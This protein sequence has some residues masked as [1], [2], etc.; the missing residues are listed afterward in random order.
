[1]FRNILTVARKNILRTTTDTTSVRIE[2]KWFDVNDN[3]SLR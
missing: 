3:T 2:D 1:M